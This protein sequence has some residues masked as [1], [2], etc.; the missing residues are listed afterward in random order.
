MNVERTTEVKT[1]RSW[2]LSI[3]EMVRAWQFHTSY[4]IDPY[5]IGGT[6]KGRCR[7][8]Y[9]VKKHRA[10]C[11][12]SKTTTDKHGVWNRPHKTKY[13]SFYAVGVVTGKMPD[14]RRH[15]GWL[16]VGHD[17]VVL[18]YPTGEPEVLAVCP[19]S[20]LVNLTPL[21]EEAWNEWLMECSQLCQLCHSQG[22]DVVMKPASLALFFYNKVSRPTDARKL[23]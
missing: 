2:F 12:Y 10:E 4:V 5:P 16:R 13:Q 22:A 17:A 18:S 21:E 20:G 6:M 7:L 9:D 1:I 8:E 23:K 19:V 11:R 14:E 3:S 15:A